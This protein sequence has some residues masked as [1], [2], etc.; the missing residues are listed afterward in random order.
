MAELYRGVDWKVLVL[1]LQEPT[2]D[3]AGIG[4]N[5]SGYDSRKRNILWRAMRKGCG[6]QQTK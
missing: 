4:V 5:Y 3:R 1:Y 2:G 6:L